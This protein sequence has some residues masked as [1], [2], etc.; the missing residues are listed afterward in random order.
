MEPVPIPLRVANE[1][2]RQHHRHNAP[3][4]GCRFAVGAQAD[5]RLV[6]VAIAGR[7]VAR[8]LDDGKTLEVLRVCTDGTRN[9]AS[10]LYS[11]V[12]RIA[13]LFGY[14]RVLTYSLQEESGA[15]LRAVGARITGE[16]RPQGWDVPSRRRRDQG[17]YAKA[18]WRWDL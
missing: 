15:S 12:K 1:F 5:G 6:G 13:Q 11:R 17:V 10:W 16:V 4:T 7:P 18:K 2:V 9:A 8:R 3:V 14:R